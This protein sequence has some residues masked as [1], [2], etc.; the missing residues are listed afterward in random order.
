MA[1]G[2]TANWRVRP[3]GNN[4][5][6]G[7][8][9]PGIASPG[10]DF[11]QQNTAQV[12]FNGTTVRATTAGVGAVITL[13]GYSATAA[14]I[15]NCLHITGGT[16]FITGWYF[17]T[18]QGGSTWTLDRNCTSGAGA[19]MTGNMGGGWADPFTNTTT[20]AAILVPGNNVFILGSGTPNPSSYTLDYT[21]PGTAVTFAAGD[22]TNGYISFLNDPATPGY[23]ASPDT[24][25]GMPTIK[26]PIGTGGSNNINLSGNSL[27]GLWFIWTASQAT[28]SMINQTSQTRDTIIG[29]V[30]DLFNSNGRVLQLV[31]GG[32]VFGCEG[33]TSVT[34]AGP[35]NVFLYVANP[36]FVSSCNI[37]DLPSTLGGITA[38]GPI[39]V[40]N[41]I[42]AKTAGDGVILPSNQTT[43][44]VI[45][46][47]VDGNTG[48]GI[49]ID[50][51]TG[52]VDREV[53][54]NTIISNHTGVGKFGLRNSGDRNATQASQ[55]AV[56]IDYNTYYNNTANYSVINAGVHDT[57][58]I[59]T[60]Y[61]ASSTGNY[62][63]A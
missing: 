29:C 62:A 53:V 30:F 45:N 5:N 40:A 54:F 38:Q 56:F 4:A 35:S 59:V 24:T 55:I 8:F 34:G 20:G 48:N 43:A 17:I 16:N 3:S 12:A 63:L 31:G 6:G 46:C 61:V 44:S 42:I 10:T 33:F 25:G 11:S 18:A 37:H 22:T 47:T 26:V 52:Q 1:V 23:K 60:P 51:S 27:E 57:A 2:A 14:D 49:T 7:G 13:V 21:C 58:L 15:A 36:S 19:A 9:D 39:T 32:Y 41:C 50:I 28:D